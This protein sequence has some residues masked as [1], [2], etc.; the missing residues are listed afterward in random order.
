MFGEFYP[1]HGD[2][3]VSVVTMPLAIAAEAFGTFLMVLFIFALTEDANV[4]KP[5]SSTQPLFIG[6]T[7]S[8]CICLIGPL[9]QAG[10][11]PARDFGPRV[12]AW[13]MGWGSAAL[14]D[15]MGGFFWVYILGPIVGAFLAALFYIYVIEPAEKSVNKSKK[16]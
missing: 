16:I 9:T 10:F 15:K 2:A 3:Q 4:G 1:N 7:V 14:P 8:M 5:D 6:L 13:L 12:V 11:N